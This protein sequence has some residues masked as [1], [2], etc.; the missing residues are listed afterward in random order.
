MLQAQDKA[1]FS[2]TGLSPLLVNVLLRRVKVWEGWRGRNVEK[3]ICGRQEEGTAEAYLE[4]IPF[5]Q[6]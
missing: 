4:Y 5:M 6:E 1:F 3:H 2:G